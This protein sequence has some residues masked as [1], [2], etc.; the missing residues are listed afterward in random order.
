MIIGLL[1]DTHGNVER[2]RSAAAIFRERAVE[3]ILHAGDVCGAEIL[4]ELTALGVP[5]HAVRGN[6]DYG[7]VCLPSVRDLTLDGRRIAVI[8]GDVFIDLERALRGQEFDY[9]ITGH[10]HAR[11]DEMR[12]RTRIINPGAVHRAA[13]PSVAI[14]DTSGGS[15][16]YVSLQGD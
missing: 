6:M 9:V 3:I 7:D 14:L 11:R 8:H 15:L 13:Q 12:G 4:D 1:S 5:V 16:E 2:T 10:T